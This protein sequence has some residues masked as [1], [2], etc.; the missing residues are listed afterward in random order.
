MDGIDAVHGDDV[1]AGHDCP[2]QQPLEGREGGPGEIVADG[3]RFRVV[4]A[5][6]EEQAAISQWLK[7]R[8][9]AASGAAPAPGASALMSAGLRLAGVLFVVA[10]MG[11]GL[12]DLVHLHDSGGGPA[13]HAAVRREEDGQKTENRNGEDGTEVGAVGKAEIGKAET[14][15]AE[16]GARGKQKAESTD[17]EVGV[18]GVAAR[19]VVKAVE[20]ALER[21]EGKLAGVRKDLADWQ[22][23]PWPTNEAGQAG[24]PE[25]SQP[26]EP[27]LSLAA[28]VF[29]LL[30]ALDPDN[31]IRKAP[32]L[33]VFLLHFRQ[34]LS[35]S[36]VARVCGYSQTLVA[37]RL[38]SIREKLP[39]QPHQLRALSAHVE[40]M[41][42]ALT[43]SRA[44]RVYRKGAV[45]GD[46][47]GDEGSE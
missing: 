12:G 3:K 13:H 19:A 11:G 37:E 46:E 6:E 38:R 5:T 22:K 30:T 39:W 2:A 41:Q 35:R 29:E 45:Y 33:K 40:A 36:Q 34:N 15:K 14:Q 26:D 20:A 8:A 18:P 10:G 43:D 1:G 27:N 31:R 17:L 23:S 9:A 32:P 7:K 21:F 44:R 24:P 42:E 28:K 16:R 4:Q 47:E 25:P